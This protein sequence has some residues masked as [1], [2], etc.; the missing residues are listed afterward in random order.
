MENSSPP[1]LFEV[2]YQDEATKLFFFF[3]RTL[4]NRKSAISLFI[5]RLYLLVC[6]VHLQQQN[7]PNNAVST[8][9]GDHIPLSE[10]YSSPNQLPVTSPPTQED[11]WH[12]P[13]RLRELDTTVLSMCRLRTKQ[14]QSK[15]PPACAVCFSE[16][17]VH[18]E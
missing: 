7:R 14:T 9:H 17:C 1:L 18:Q 2:R 6:M 5:C 16:S 8:T 12:L 13:G 11:L 4:N 10:H 15:T 3:E